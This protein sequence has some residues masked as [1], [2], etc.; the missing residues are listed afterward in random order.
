MKTEKKE[1][2]RKGKKERKIFAELWD[3]ATE[4]YV[5]NSEDFINGILKLSKEKG[6][7]ELQEKLFSSLWYVEV[8]ENLIVLPNRDPSPDYY[9]R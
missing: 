8:D 1:N 5:N 3:G 6:F 9:F 4:I 7:N 2:K